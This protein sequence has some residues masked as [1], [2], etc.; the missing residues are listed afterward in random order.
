MADRNIN[1]FAPQLPLPTK[2]GEVFVVDDWDNKVTQTDLGFNYFGGNTGATETSA[3]TTTLDVAPVSKGSV[4]GS[5][6]ISFNFTGQAPEV[7][8]GYF[9]SL[10]GLTDTDVSLDGTTIEKGHPFAGY[11]LD[12]QNLYR[13]FLPLAG[14][15]VDQLRF[16]VRLESSQNV[17]LKIELQDEQHF[18]VFARR[19][20]MSTGSWQTLTFSLLSDFTDSVAGQGDPRA[21]DWH[22]VS[23][24]ALIIERVNVGAGITNPDTGRFLVDNL[25]FIDVDGRYPD[26]QQARDP[27]DGS[28]VHLYNEAFLDQVRATSSLYFLD[29]ASTD[30][31]T[32]GIIQDRST[33]ADLMSVGGVGFQLTS[34]VVDAQQGYLSRTDAATRVRDILRVLRDH[35]QGADRVG[36]IGN[37]GFFYHFL[38]IDGLRKQNFDVPTTPQLESLHTVELSPIDTALAIAGMVTTAQYFGDSS[39][40]ETEIRTLVDEIYGRV[41]W[42]FMLDD[43]RFSNTHQF[44]LGWKPNEPRDDDSGSFG[45]FKLNDDPAHPLGQYAS[46]QVGGMEV[47]ATLDFY[48]DEGQL[49]ALLAMGSPNPQHRLSRT[50]WDAIIRDNEGG[51]F[52][53]TYP[54]SLFTYQFGSAWLDRQ[55]LG[56]DNHPSKP[57]NFYDNTRD[58]IQATR[59]YA[60]ANPL[61]HATLNANRWGLSATEGPFDDYFAEAAPPAAIHPGGQEPAGGLVTGPGGPIGLEGEDGTGDGSIMF[62]SNASS[63]RTVQLDTGETRT[64]T[65]ELAS[66]TSY[67]VAVRYSND[68]SGALETVTVSID[69]MPVGSFEAQDTGDFGAGWNNF[70][71][72]GPIGTKIL[73]QG[74]HLLRVS[75]SGGDGFGVEID[76][77]NLTPKPVPR[78]LEFGTVTNYAVGSA[79]IHTPGE[80]LAALWNSAAHEDLNQDAIPEMLHPRFGFA[81][82]FN[83]NIANVLSDSS[84]T[85]KRSVGPWADF[86]GFAIDHGPMLVLMDNYL[87]HQFV[88]DLF[89]S[90]PSVRNALVTLFPDAPLAAF[91]SLTVDDVSVAEGDTGTVNATFT[92]RLSSS[93][94][95]PVTL[96]YATT[97]GT[98]TDPGDYTAVA[99]TILNFQPG[100]TAKTI[101]VPIKG[102][103]TLETDETFF[104]NLSNASNAVLDDNQSQGTIRND[105]VT[106]NVPPINIV[107][108]VQTV[109][110]GNA[111]LL[112][113]VNGNG[114]QIQDFDSGSAN[115]TANLKTKNGT[116]VLAIGYNTTI[117]GYGTKNLTL[118][119]T[120]ANLNKALGTLFYQTTALGVDTLTIKTT[121]D[122]HATDTDTIN[123][124]VVSSNAN[125]APVNFVPTLQNVVPGV[126]FAFNDTIDNSLRIADVDSGFKPVSVK[127]GV[128]QGKLKIDSTVGLTV[129]GNNTKTLLLTGRVD[130]INFNLQYLSYTAN[131]SFPG[132]DVLTITTNDLG[133]TGIG[134]AKSDVDTVALTGP[135]LPSNQPPVN[136]VPGGQTVSPGSSLLFNSVNGNAIQIH[137]PDAGAG[138][139]T[140]NLKASS[141]TLAIAIAY[142]T[143]ITGYGTNNMTLTGSL[144]NLNQALGTL[145]YQASVFAGIDTLTI[146]TN[147]NENFGSGGPKIAISTVRVNVQNHVNGAPA[148]FVPAT[149]RATLGIPLAFKNSNNNSI[150]VGDVDSGYGNV[151]V[152]LTVSQ[153]KLTLSSFVG[154]SITGNSTKAVT[155]IGRVD[156][157]NFSLQSL[158]Y[159]TDLGVSGLDNLIVIIDDQGNTGT[160]G[161]QTATKS[162][163]LTLN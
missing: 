46:K 65:F 125:S 139:L 111:L 38:G 162:V 114:L 79:I 148:V 45:R 130:H 32:G 67:E 12:T 93:S 8:A 30:P 90:Y 64:L 96:T 159:I 97:N 128:A 28:L 1:L 55:T 23:S 57:I 22:K 119:G 43:G 156:H 158:T 40:I 91:P 132:N 126:P 98:A 7:F 70:L 138:K 34:Y 141:G 149:Q 25:E 136:E 66:T 88:P 6:D 20:L 118:T 105:D 9:A 155:L 37:Q 152:T 24:F 39:A 100:Q 163:S 129:T 161:R 33:S 35:P 72:S 18:D 83:V 19:T 5:L 153:G 110:L 62:R 63:G 74:S 160:G 77:A 49:I 113:K 10:F 133:N 95:Q 122:H 84:A 134:G 68:N 44:F 135:V 146:T 29:F 15:T 142:G 53:K 150:K 145:F 137:D 85:R 60:I 31:R 124:N 112:N 76:I 120:L 14:R 87:E 131:L 144:A 116:L 2:T 140:V 99:P 104:V 78:P 41:N 58:A 117:S 151:K 48:T 47:P 143:T 4:G 36:T 54:G 42:N 27:I 50:V 82:A 80:A 21:F 69:G 147:D 75:V 52:I 157:L 107:P 103:M 89:M 71:T 13:G 102:D 127:L 3:N 115:L 123:V 16:D 154:A 86:T 56:K 61:G 73:P 101:T 51:S 92:V 59:D 109:V 26:L 106:T 108:G 81:D 121:D 17:T 94:S 11:F